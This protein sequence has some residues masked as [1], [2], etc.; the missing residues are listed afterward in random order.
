MSPTIPDDTNFKPYHGFD[1]PTIQADENLIADLYALDALW[2]PP[3]SPYEN[4]PVGWVHNVLH[5]ET[6]SLQREIYQA[7]QANRYTAVKSCHGPGKSYTAAQ[8]I[9][10]WIANKPDPFV[11]TSAPTSHQVRT[12]LWREIKRAKERPDLPL[13]GKITQGQ[14]PEWKDETGEI[15]AFGRKPADY[16]DQ[17]EAASAFQGIHA[18]SLLVVLDE[19]SGIP[20]WLASAC[21]NLITNEESRLLII[22]NPDNP[23][24]YFARAFKPGSDFATISIPA[25]QTPNFTAEKHEISKD[26]QARLTSEIWVSERAKRWGTQSPMYQSKVN[27]EFPTVT[28]DTVFTPQ[29]MAQAIA[30][31]LEA[32]Q[33]LAKKGPFASNDIMKPGVRLGMDVARLGSDETVV[34]QNYFGHTRMVAR[35]SKK[36][37]ME[38]VG[39]YRR[40]LNNGNSPTTSPPT[41]IDVNGLGAGV[42]DRL[43]E[44]NYN[45]IPFNGGE[46]A[47][48]PTKYRNRRSEAYWET[49]ELFEQGAIDIETDDEDLQAE[50][51]ET[52]FKDTSTGLKAI[53][54]KEDIAQRL[55]H[56]PDRADAFV[57]CHQRAASFNEIKETAQRRSTRADKRHKSTNQNQKSA[58]V[59]MQEQDHTQDFSDPNPNQTTRAPAQ[60]IVSDIMTT[61][62]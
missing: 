44:L 13:K 47:Y 51:L 50:L 54:P 18:Q 57:M 1:S 7:V 60:D 36:D 34:Y 24:S 14:V 55:G 20:D 45:V 9:C 49:R 15:L 53:E 31:E 29:H 11:V 6:W 21:E 10:W 32:P 42:Y 40:L 27:A 2:N 56:S 8:L 5:S 39:A 23:V 37:T 52:H 41:V 22:G 19:G 58:S 17:Q 61:D 46:K 33:I 38:T 62:F 28:D 16:L 3:P 59:K 26:L 48:N 30:N 12:I 35:W 4:D 25:H 43:R